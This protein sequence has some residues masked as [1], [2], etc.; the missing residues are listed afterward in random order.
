[1]SKIRLFTPGPVPVLPQA[2]KAMSEPIIHHRSADFIAILEEV[3]KG[4]KDLVETKQEVLLLAS[5]GTGAMEGTVV[6]LF[7]PQDKVIV[8]RAG[9]FGERWVHIANAFGL[10]VVPLDIPWGEA[11]TRE[12]IEK[13]FKENPESKGILIQACETSTGVDFPVQEI[14]AF[15]RTQNVLLVVDAI[16]YLGVSPFQMDAWGV[17]ALVSGSQKGLMLPP[18]LS[19]VCLSERAWSTQKKSKLPRYYFDFAKELKSMTQNQTAYT[20]AVSLI[21]GLRE[22][23]H[24]FKEQGKENIFLKYKTY[25][26]AMRE[27]AQALQLEL[28]AK[29][30]SHGLVSI[31]VPEKIDGQKIVRELRDRYQMTIAGGQD[32]LKGKILRISCMG[33]IDALDLVSVFAALEKVLKQEGAQIPFGKGVERLQVRLL[34]EKV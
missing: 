18:G 7:S 27:A 19:F 14:A 4:L 20:P 25:S 13:A 17:D 1:M 22:V 12:Q 34:G 24:Y 16:S 3:R 23:L 28:F 11:P 5:S 30:P 8:A 32:Q 2:L 9:K 33:H 6:N 29:S 26:D 15:T 10:N 21:L 31:R